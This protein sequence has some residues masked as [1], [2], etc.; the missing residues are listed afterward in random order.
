MMN[1]YA[2]DKKVKQFEVMASQ[3]HKQTQ[4]E[5]WKKNKGE[6]W[7]QNYRRRIEKFVVDVDENPTDYDFITMNKHKK[8]QAQKQMDKMSNLGPSHFI[9]RPYKSEKERVKEAILKNNCF[10]TEPINLAVQ[11]HVFRERNHEKEISADMRFSTRLPSGNCPKGMLSKSSSMAMNF[12]PSSA[13]VSQT[14]FDPGL[15]LHF[16][17]ALSMLLKLGVL[18]SHVVRPGDTEDNV[19]LRYEKLAEE[20]IQ[21]GPRKMF[22]K[23]EDEL[24]QKKSPKKEVKK[25]IKKEVELDP[26]QEEMKNYEPRMSKEDALALA[27]KLLMKALS[28][29]GFCYLPKIA[30]KNDPILIAAEKVLVKTDF[31]KRTMRYKRKLGAQRNVGCAPPVDLIK[32]SKKLKL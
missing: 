7:I 14:D 1:I 23:P 3:T 12:S 31:I 2:I 30:K 32:L 20:S 19:Y 4:W 6:D 22:K 16:K 10:M 13:E 17:S 26:E 28:F 8:Q 27:K 24:T 29:T 5:H 15:K 21:K 11:N 9:F 25:E 18:K